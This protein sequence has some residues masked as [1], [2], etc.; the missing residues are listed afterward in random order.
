MTTLLTNQLKIVGYIPPEE[1]T[2]LPRASEDAWFPSSQAWVPLPQP[3]EAW[4]GL[5][6]RRRELCSFGEEG[7]RI[8]PTPAFLSLPQGGLV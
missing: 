6:A 8:V 2:L 7:V 4:V 5:G 1:S 3:T